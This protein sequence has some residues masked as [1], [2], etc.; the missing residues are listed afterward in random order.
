MTQEIDNYARF[1]ALLKRLPGADK[2]TLVYQYTDGR[3]TH[4]RQMEPDE[5]DRMCRRMEQ[6]AGYEERREA[7]RRETKKKRSACLKLM[8]QMGIDT[9]DWA[10]VNDF[11][12]NPRIAGKPFARIRPEELDR[13]AAKLRSIMRKGGLK[14]REEKPEVKQPGRAACLYIGPETPQC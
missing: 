9:T 10:R 8:Q 5:Y 13:L 11:C 7:R 12:V 1:Y 3:T 14:P 4:L 6:V 2:E